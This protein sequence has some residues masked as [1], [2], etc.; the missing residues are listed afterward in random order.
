MPFDTY[1]NLKQNNLFEKKK[2][3]YIHALIQKKIIIMHT[4]FEIK[5]LAKSKK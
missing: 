4:S 1:L 2:K 3:R 5:L